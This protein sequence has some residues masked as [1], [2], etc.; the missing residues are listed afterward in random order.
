MF[1][2]T[3]FPVVFN[4]WLALIIGIIMTIVSKLLASMNQPGALSLESVIVG[5]FSG[6]FVCMAWEFM[7]DLPGFGNFFVKKFGLKMDGTA[8]YFVRIFFIALLLVLIMSFCM[9]FIE[10]GFG[11]FFML[12]VWA[13]SILPMLAAAYISVLILFNPLLALTGMMCTKDPGPGAFPG[14]PGGPGGPGGH[15]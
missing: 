11:L 5:S 10:M 14:A 15:P 4:F 1:K 7:I 13:M 9:M 6:F 2:K 8:A 3:S 12:N